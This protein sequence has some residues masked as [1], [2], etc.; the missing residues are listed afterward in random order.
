MLR[1]V[2]HLHDHLAEVL[3]DPTR[4]TLETFW[5]WFLPAKDAY[6]PGE[7]VLLDDIVATL[8]LLLWTWDEARAPSP[9]LLASLSLE[10]V[11]LLSYLPECWTE[12]LPLLALPVS[13]DWA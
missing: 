10:R 3:A 11:R 1:F 12:Q 9:L 4:E 2:K 13:S 8:C 7:D 6:P 5:R